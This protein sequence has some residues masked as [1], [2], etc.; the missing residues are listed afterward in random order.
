M[1]VDN[2]ETLLDVTSNAVASKY[3]WNICLYRGNWCKQ[4]NGVG[5]ADDAINCH[6]TNVK[7]HT[8]ED[9]TRRPLYQNRLL[10]TT[11]GGVLK[12]EM[13]VD[14]NYINCSHLIWM[15]EKQLCEG[16]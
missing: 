9:A 16:E 12:M 14:R 2:G 5:G 15:R 1:D 7:G 6:I 10:Q 8:S 13:E 4:A 3:L 11:V